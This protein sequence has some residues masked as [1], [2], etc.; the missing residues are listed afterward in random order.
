MTGEMAAKCGEKSESFREE[1]NVE[2]LVA[3]GN[4]LLAQ[5]KYDGAIKTFD[6][7]LVE[8]QVVSDQEEIA[9]TEDQHERRRYQMCQELDAC[10]WLLQNRWFAA[11]R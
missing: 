10:H 2:K 4:N 9:A 6:R 5:K 3:L 11:S 7:A 8:A 1:G